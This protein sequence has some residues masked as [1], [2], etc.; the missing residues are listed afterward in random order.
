[1][2]GADWGNV[3]LDTGEASLWLVVEHNEDD[4]QFVAYHDYERAV[5]H[6]EQW[7][8]LNDGEV[9]SCHAQRVVIH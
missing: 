8:A 6:V 3:D 9:G 1:V 4:T 7:H 5:K 2:N